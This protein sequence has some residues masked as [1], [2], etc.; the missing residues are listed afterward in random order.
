M[1]SR[2]RGA[3]LVVLAL[4]PG[5]A[6]ARDWL[7]DVTA[8]GV[9]IGTYRFTVDEAGDARHVVADARFRLRLLVVDAFSYEHHAEETWQG[10]CLVRLES[11]TVEQGRTTTVTAREDGDAFVIDA[12]HGRESTARCPM[13]FAYWN[14]RVLH[15]R[16]LINTQT[17]MPTPVTITPMGSERIDVRATK[18][19]AR[20]Y[21]V[22]TERN[23]IDVWYSARDEWVALRTTTKQ[24][25]HVLQWRLR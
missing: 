8:D 19:D 6:G 18:I 17:G 11:R 20:R 15:A 22:E 5:A 12:T 7:F 16:V 24:G 9:G 23:V 14:P 25:N 3:L 10:D 4:S 21:R 1:P 13:S 2:L